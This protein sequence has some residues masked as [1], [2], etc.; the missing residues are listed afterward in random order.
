VPRQDATWLGQLVDDHGAE[1]ADRDTAR[2]D[3]GRDGD[4]DVDEDVDAAW[5]DGGAGAFFGAVTA[6]DSDAPPLFPPAATRPAET[7][8][9][10][11]RVPTT[12]RLPRLHFRGPPWDDRLGD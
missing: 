5:D 1:P 11:L 4:V 12:A 10:T 6:L 9:A 8:A 3:A 2:D 7:A